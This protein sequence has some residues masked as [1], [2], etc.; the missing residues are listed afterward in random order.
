MFSSKFSLNL[1]NEFLVNRLW[2]SSLSLDS[3]LIYLPR[4][5]SPLG[6]D[7]NLKLLKLLLKFEPLIFDNSSF[8]LPLFFFWLIHSTFW[9]VTKFLLCKN[10]CVFL[11]MIIKYTFRFVLVEYFIQF[12]IIILLMITFFKWFNSIKK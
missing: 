7:V 2:V 5:A 6:Y 12:W 1:C 4:N 10:I 11:V 9:S 8:Y 3:F